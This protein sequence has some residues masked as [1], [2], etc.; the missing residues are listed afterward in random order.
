[1]I[2]AHLLYSL[3]SL[4]TVFSGSDAEQFIEISEP[5]SSSASFSQCA[6][7]SE[8]PIL[9][10]SMD[11]L[12][13]E[14]CGDIKLY[15]LLELIPE[16]A[17]SSSEDLCSSFFEKVVRGMRMKEVVITVRKKVPQ[18]AN[19]YPLYCST[20]QR[21]DLTVSRKADNLPLILVEVHSSPFAATVNKTILV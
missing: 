10:G 11:S 3:L 4:E 18:F 15:D 5:S 6:K 17:S 1:M 9:S 16:V 2:I 7:F 19:L 13:P 14:E 8:F 21:P 20:D 12:W